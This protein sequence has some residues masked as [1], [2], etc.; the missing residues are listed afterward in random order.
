[1]CWLFIYPFKCWETRSSSICLVM[2]GV[3]GGFG[4]WIS[5]NASSLIDSAGLASLSVFSSCWRQ[6]LGIWHAT[7]GGQRC[8]PVE[9]SMPRYLLTMEVHLSYV[10]VE[11]W[12]RAS[13][14]NV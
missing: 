11:C 3:F 9:F 1:M 8:A 2:A 4:A 6:L 5:L 10:S 13:Y 12:L 7:T 14:C